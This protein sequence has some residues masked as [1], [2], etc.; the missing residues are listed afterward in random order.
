MKTATFF[1]PLTAAVSMSLAPSIQ[2]Q[3]TPTTLTQPIV[4]AQAQNQAPVAEQRDA[5]FRSVYGNSSSAPAA[6]A[7]RVAPP[8]AAVPVV[9]QAVVAPAQPPVEDSRFRSV[10]GSSASRGPA[11]ARGGAGVPPAVVPGAP[12]A[13]PVV[14]VPV[15][16]REDPEREQR[17]IN[18]QKQ[19]AISGNPSSQYDL[20]MRYVKGDGVEQDDKQALEW[21]KLSAKSGNGRAKKELAALE[22]RLAEKGKDAPEAG[23]AT[24]KTAKPESE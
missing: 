2:A 22:K 9:P 3:V 8:A 11:T 1:I 4:N 7:P 20:G 16:R 19:N 14:A 17:I 24:A 12:T 15:V 10:Y 21:L 5:R 18:F 23:A 6:P 13:P